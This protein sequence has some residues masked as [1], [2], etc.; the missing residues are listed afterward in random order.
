MIVQYILFNDMIGI[1]PGAGNPLGLDP[2]EDSLS[3]LPSGKSKQ[4]QA[5]GSGK[6]IVNVS[7]DSED[8]LHLN[9]AKVR[10]HFDCIGCFKVLVLGRSN[11]GKT[12]LLQRVCNTT[13]FP[14]IMNAEDEKMDP[15]IVQGSLE[16]REYH[17][18]EDELIFQSNLGFFFMTHKGLRL[19]VN[20]L[21][22]MKNFVTDRAAMMKLERHIHVIW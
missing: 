5:S 9:P 16:P 7:P 6:P 10:K 22:L 15:S 13:K 20:E 21:N 11:S 3:S 14:E 4:L 17:N 2:V 18:I 1:S 19:S 8:R 12:T